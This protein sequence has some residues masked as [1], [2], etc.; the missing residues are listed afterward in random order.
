MICTPHPIYSTLAL[1]VVSAIKLSGASFI[2][3]TIIT[4]K[5]STL[6]K[7]MIFTSLLSLG[8]LLPFLGFLPK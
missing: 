6:I 5:E 8:G 4:N 2:N 1:T 3:Q 7:F